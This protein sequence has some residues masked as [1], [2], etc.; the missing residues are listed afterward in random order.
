MKREHDEYLCRTYPEIFQDRTA[1][2]T[3]TAMCWGFE[4]GDGWFK[5]LDLLC[6]R[7]QSHIKWNS[8]TKNP[9]PQVVA[10]QVKEKYGTLSF[11]YS[12]GDDYISG[13]VSMAETISS[14]T[15]ET[16][17]GPAQISDE[18]T[19]WVS[20]ICEPCEQARSRRY[21]YQAN[22]KGINYE[23]IGEETGNID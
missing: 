23:Y 7:I 11:Y 14:I 9:I 5:I 4:C 15:C 22:K 2:M 21:Q 13:L 16:C 8:N 17:G 12:G 19:G 1:A 10:T 20:T 3:Q 6:E 18:N